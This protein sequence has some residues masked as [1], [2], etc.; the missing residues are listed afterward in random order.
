ML[1]GIRWIRPWARVSPQVVGRLSGGH[2]AGE[3]SQQGR[4]MR[5]QVAVGEAPHGQAEDG[6]QREQRHRPGSPRRNPATR[7]QLSPMV[8]GSLTCWSTWAA[9]IGSWPSRWVA[10]SRRLAEKP[11]C[12]SAGRFLSRLPMAKSRVSLIVVSVRIALSSLWYCLILL[13]L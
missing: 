4:E 11:T 2:G 3:E 12:R 7:V 1:W 13:C 6:Q 10:S 8:T 5:A 9:A